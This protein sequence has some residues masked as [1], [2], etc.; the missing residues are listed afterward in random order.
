MAANDPYTWPDSDVLRNKGGHRTQAAL[1][2]FEYLQTMV[3]SL[4]MPAV[5][6]DADGYRAL[7]RHL[8]EK[9]YDWA[10]EHRTVNVS[11]EGSSFARHD[12][13]GPSLDARFQQLRWE[14]GLQDLSADRF[15]RGAAEHVAELNRIHPFREGN[16]RVM[17]M[18]LY[19]LGKHVGHS[20]DLTQL[21]APIWNK[22]SASAMD[23]DRRLLI[24]AIADL[25]EP[26]R[27]VS[28]DAAIAQ[29]RDH[30]RAALS[31]IRERESEI[32][33]AVQQGKGSTTTT[34]ELR[35]LREETSGLSSVD[36]N[37]TIRTLE[38]LKAQDV[39]EISVLPS[40]EGSARDLVHAL[41]RAAVRHGELAEARAAL[42]VS[43]APGAQ[44]SSWLDQTTQYVAGRRQAEAERK[45]PDPSL[46]QTGSTRPSGP[47]A[48]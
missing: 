30:H 6:Q 26:K 14:G 43:A 10:G 17:K 20:V 36:Y 48:G 34:K 24:H 2:D 7:H 9:V 13:I 8:F 18:H 5:A 44:A 45:T 38:A 35:A 39:S 46:P 21:D 29:V 15:A 23:G 42:G 1:D 47:G 41:D 11:K 4:S 19:Q 40:R 27:A 22:A 32:R 16:G 28:V 33:A 31:E 12:M 37:R 3:R 25:V